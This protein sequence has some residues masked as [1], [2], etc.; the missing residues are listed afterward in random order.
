MIA[1]RVIKSYEK[2]ISIYCIRPATV[3]GYSPRMRLDVSVNM[4][5][6]QALKNRSITVH[7]GK[8]IRP[9]IH[10]KDLINVYKF[11]VNKSGIK[12]GMYNAGFENLKIID[13][14]KKISKIIPSKII[15]KKNNDPRSYRQNSDKLLST[16]FKKKFNVSDAIYELKEMF[17]RKKI[18][19]S[20]RCYTVKWM[21][22]INLKKI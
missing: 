10:I 18:K 2:K 7:G 14:A 8:Q 16:G 17:E 22:K 12:S 19:E 9:N 4:L 13:I 21:K 20:D 1:E 11:F 6:F 5:T 15:I 3:C